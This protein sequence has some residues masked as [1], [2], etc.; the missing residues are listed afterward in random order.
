MELLER[1]PRELF[2]K[3]TGHLDVNSLANLY[4]VFGDIPNLVSYFE[5]RL[6]NVQ[7]RRRVYNTRNTPNYPELFFRLSTCTSCETLDDSVWH[8]EMRTLRSHFCEWCVRD[9]FVCCIC[10]FR[11]CIRYEFIIE[12]SCENE[13]RVPECNVL[14][15]FCI[16]K[17]E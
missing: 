10:N 14:E 16:Y 9:S 4:D 7:F 1:L 12:S 3:I 11:S 8:D 13:C 17:C 5:Y 2:F 6:E 15:T